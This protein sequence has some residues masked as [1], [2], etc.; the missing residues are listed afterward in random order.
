MVR[1]FIQ[2]FGRKPEFTPSRLQWLNTVSL[3]KHFEFEEMGTSV[4]M[5]SWANPNHE[6]SG[7][8]DD[9]LLIPSF[10]RNH[11][12]LY[13]FTSDSSSSAF[14]ASGED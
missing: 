7:A 11:S 12:P 10:H 1:P 8:L 3:H 13:I 5:L 4:R 9:P 6:R 14:R 2:V